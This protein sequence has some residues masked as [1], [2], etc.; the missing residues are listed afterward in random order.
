MP[1]N[2]KKCLTGTG[3]CGNI[4]VHQGRAIKKKIERKDAGSFGKPGIP[5]KKDRKGETRKT[6]PWSNSK[7]E[8]ESD[9]L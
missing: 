3:A 8:G 2:L 7:K 9:V 5:G 4:K 1:K 6:S